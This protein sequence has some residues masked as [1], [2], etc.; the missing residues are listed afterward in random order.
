MDWLE[1]LATAIISLGVFGIIFA[2]IM[3]WL[4]AKIF[5]NMDPKQRT[6]VLSALIVGGFVILVTGIGAP[7]G[8]VAILTGALAGV[9]GLL[10]KGE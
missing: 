8:A 5:R 10:T 7:L 9:F 2:A 3:A 1:F 6:L 4:L